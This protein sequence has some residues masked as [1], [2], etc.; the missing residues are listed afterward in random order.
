MSADPTLTT[1][2]VKG[3]TDRNDVIRVFDTHVRITA[4]GTVGGLRAVFS[5]VKPGSTN[6]AMEEE[7]EPAVSEIDV[8][9]LVRTVGRVQLGEVAGS[10]EFV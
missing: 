9:G 6:P 10:F 1:P 2:G 8:V 5:P 7:T 4:G 3:R